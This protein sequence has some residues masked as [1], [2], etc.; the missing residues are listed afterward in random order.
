MDPS[1]KASE[2]ILNPDGSLYHL[3]LRPGQVAETIITVGDPERVAQVSD[4]FDRVEQRT[5]GREFVTHTGTFRGQRLT[6]ISTGI[7]TDNVDIVIN[8]LD[9]LFNV[10]L[11]RRSLRREL[12]SL[13]FLRLGT[14]GAFQPDLELGSFLLSDAAIGLDGL[15][16]YYV[17]ASTNHPAVLNLRDH[18]S[19]VRLQLPVR[20]A[21]IL[22]S[23]PPA[24][25]T[26]DLPRGITLTAAGFYGPQ[27]RRLR[28][29]TALDEVMLNRLRS[30]TYREQRITNIEMETS[31]LYALAT[32]LG[33]RSASL[34]VLLANRALNTFHDRPKR[35]VEELIT[36][37][38]DL[39]VPPPSR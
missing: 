25:E 32:R 22:P 37:G 26:S 10:D 27:G 20:P 21:F 14:S 15:L 33:H 13:T 9:A 3:H 1:L 35:A 31:G 30:W 5:T 17:P 8:E 38:L 36:R 12:T 28:L 24:F 18:L 11:E 6:V 2:L 23:L 34:S 7:G 39:L 19:D 29:K 4:R 16:P